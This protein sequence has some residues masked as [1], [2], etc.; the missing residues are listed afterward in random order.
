MSSSSEQRQSLED[1]IK[2]LRLENTHLRD[3]LLMANGHLGLGQIRREEVEAQI[4]LRETVLAHI[5]DFAYLFDLDGRF[6]YINRALLSLWQKSLE[7]AV[8]KNFFDLDYPPDLAARLQR[9]IQQVIDTKIAV[10]DETPYTGADGTTGVYEYILVPVFNS[11][12]GSVEAVAGSTRD[13]TERKKSE[14]ALRESE[15]RFSA[16]FAQAPVAMVLMTPQGEF[17]DAN[18]TYL[19]M[20]GCSAAELEGRTSDHFTHPDD[21]ALTHQFGDAFRQG[22]QPAPLEKRYIRKDGSVIWV[23]ASGTMRRD[24]DGK[25][26]QFI[27]IL[28]DI[29]QRKS[30]EESLKTSEERLQQTFQQAPVAICVLRGSKLVFELVNP[31][32]QKLFPGRELLGRSL[33]SAVPEVSAEVLGILNQVLTSGVTFVAEEF[34]IPLDRN[35]DG[36]VEDYWFNFVYHPLRESQAAVS[37]VVTVAVDVT[38]HVLARQALERANRELEEFAYVASHDLQEPLRMINIYTQLLIRELQPHLSDRTSAYATSIH[39]G[40]RRMEQLLKD[41]LN[42]SHTLLS[43]NEPASLPAADLSVALAR[44]TETLQNSIDECKAVVTADPLPTVSGDEAQLTQVFQNLLSNALKY[45]KHGESPRIHIVAQDHLHEW[46]VG[47][48]DNGIGFD[49]EQAGRVFGLFKRLHKDEYP[50]TGLG[51]AICKRLIER[52]S[53]RIWAEAKLGEG[54]TFWFALPKPNKM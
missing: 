12:D 44:A 24:L 9:Q 53:G 38:S 50:G 30:A 16:A 43:E 23:R 2:R 54:A 49:Q 28:E 21:V 3:Q 37:A 14:A 19:N 5:P 47:V 10:R 7:T 36:L 20:L 17:V 18:Q 25:P 11:S 39:K 29:T 4:R 40:V 34:R 52:Y 41:L 15:Q 45:R 1:E 33:L 31:P 26:T 35:H 13:I 22:S 27:A 6:T 8:G 48:Q 51:L 46:I 32:Y 42:V